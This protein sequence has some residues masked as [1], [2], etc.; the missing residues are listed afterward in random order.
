MKTM[1]ISEQP[2]PLLV[3]IGETGSGKSALAIELALQ[4][5]GEIICADSW[6]VRRE[7]T[8]GT[9]KPTPQQQALVP[10]HLLDIVDPCED[11]TAAVFK[12]LA[13]DKIRDITARGKL[14][15]MVG[16]TGLYIDGVLFDFNFLPAGDPSERAVLNQL[17]VNE[18]LAKIGELGLE[19]GTIDTRNKRRLIRLLETKGAQQLRQPLRAHTVMLGLQ[20]DRDVLAARIEQRIDGMLAAGLE[21]EVD[22]LQARYGWDCEALKGVGYSQWQPYF[23]GQKSPTELK[24]TKQRI[25][26]ATF[27]LAKRQRTWFS[28]NKSIHWLSIPIDLAAV[29]DLAT[30][31]LSK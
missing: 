1:T 14:P 10:H 7:V 26:K 27:D 21:Q 31:L 30:T 20:G 13:N 22:Q 5:D 23:L 29:V 15:I 12:R 11:F 3:I 24:A 6:T 16:G 17:S 8:I 19:L 2:G 4:L 18:L 28:R 9:A 25:L